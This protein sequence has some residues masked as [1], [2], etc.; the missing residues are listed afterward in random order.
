L[1]CQGNILLA[2]VEVPGG[3]IAGQDD[4]TGIGFQS[5]TFSAI[6]KKK[7]EPD[8]VVFSLTLRIKYKCKWNGIK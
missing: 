8:W 2:G 4:R 6:Q 7:F 3:I 1:F 5:E